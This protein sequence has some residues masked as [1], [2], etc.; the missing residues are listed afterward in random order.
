MTEIAL[1]PPKAHPTGIPPLPIPVEMYPY[2]NPARTVKVKLSMAVFPV[3]PTSLFAGAKIQTL[4]PHKLTPKL[5]TRL[6][7]PP[8]PALRVVWMAPRNLLSLSLVP[9]F[10]HP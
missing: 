5:R 3:S 4:L 2:F 8:L 10:P 7:G 1:L 9:F 6:S